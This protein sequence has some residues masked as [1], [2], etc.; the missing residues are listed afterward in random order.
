MIIKNPYNNK[1]IL[2]PD[3]EM[4]FGRN[5]EIETVKSLLLNDYPQCVSIIGERRIGK[6]SLAIRILK[7]LMDPKTIP[8]YLDYDGINGIKTKDEFFLN[9]NYEFINVVNTH[10]SKQYFTKYRSN[11][12]FFFDYV[13]SKKFFKQISYDNFKTIIFI[14]EFEYLPEQSY[15][16]DVFFSNL[17]FLANTP[18]IRLA[19]VTIS[20]QP[21]KDLTHQSIK[22]SGFWTIFTTETIG[23]LDESNINKLRI[24]GFEKNNLPIQAD[25]KKLID[26]Y[27][28]YFPFFNQLVCSRLFYSK[29]TGVLINH[30]QLTSEVEPF[31]NSIW[32]SRIDKEKELL[33]NLYE[34]TEKSK[35]LLIEMQLRGI[36]I[37]KNNTYQPF[38]KLFSKYIHRQSL[39]NKLDNPVISPLF[40]FDVFF[41]Y[42]SSERPF[43]EKIG[44]QLKEMGINPWIDVWNLPPGKPWQDVI[45]EQINKIQAA[46]I[47]IGESGIGPWHNLEQTALMNNFVKRKST[48]IP[49]ILPNCKKEP[50]IPLFLEGITMVD[51]RIK[52]PDPFRQLV[53]GIL[54]KIK[55]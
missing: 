16:D 19:F 21:L 30:E 7:Q 1:K 29:I 43:I 15:A 38:S 3:S 34:I 4:F 20:K 18:D 17:R 40:H 10:P 5:Y 27:S 54:D 46:V 41:S 35:N 28:G 26:N 51:F 49:A 2:S 55:F 13:S 39:D 25:D 11:N 31:Y 47:F 14:D 48:I 23:L 24:F 37:Q 6:S 8:I 53:W 36:V 52:N 9:I 12:T 32:N 22:A 33:S 44:L 50:E 45:A 42:N